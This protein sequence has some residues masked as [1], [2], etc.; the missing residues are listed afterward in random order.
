MIYINS[1]CI[2]WR[3]K[4]GA[5][6]IIPSALLQL[7]INISKLPDSKVKRFYLDDF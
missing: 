7:F 2:M 1:L 6:S 3:P 5:G 4:I